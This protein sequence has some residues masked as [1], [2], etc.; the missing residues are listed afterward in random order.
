MKA[1]YVP[2]VL[3]EEGP[4]EMR[5]KSNRRVPSSGG[6]ML[7]FILT[8]VLFAPLFTFI[9]GGAS[10]EF[11]Y[12]GPDSTYGTL[13]DALDNASA[14]DIVILSEGTFNGSFRSG[15]S[16][17]VIRGNSTEGTIL[18]LDGD[19][20][21]ILE[22]S[23]IVL[24]SLTIRNGTLD[25]T[26][27]NL[28]GSDIIL[29][30]EGVSIN[31]I[32][33]TGCTLNNLSMEDT[34]GTA[35]SMTNCSSMKLAA[36]ISSNT[37]GDLIVI[38]SCLNVLIEDPALHLNKSS[39]GIVVSRSSIIS[40]TNPML[41]S[42][43]AGCT[44]M[45]L[46]NST[47]VTISSGMLSVK[48]SG[49]HLSHSSMVLVNG[50]M[51][52]VPQG[53]Y[54]GM[55]GELSDN[56]TV[57]SVSFL[58]QGS[59]KGMEL[60]QT[61]DLEVKNS[62]MTAGENATGADILNCIRASFR[63][64][65]VEGGGNR[66][67]GILIRSSRDVIIGFTD[68]STTSSD[69]VFV[70]A[71]NSTSV[72]LK[73]GD[74]NIGGDLSTGY[75]ETDICWNG[76]IHDN[77]FHITGGGAFGIRTV[78]SVDHLFDSNIYDIK[79]DGSV[80]GEVAGRRTVIDGEY[81]SAA[82]S[83]S[84]GMILEG[85]SISFASTRTYAIGEEST[86]VKVWDLSYL[87]MTGCLVDARGKSSSGMDVV[88]LSG[89]YD[90]TGCSFR[91]DDDSGILIHFDD[92][93]SIIHFSNS[94]LSSD[95][96]APA[97]WIRTLSSELDGID[98]A[99]NDIGLLVED[100]PS[101]RLRGV[102]INA[103][104]P[105]RTRDSALTVRDSEMGNA[106]MTL[107]AFGS[108]NVHF[109]DT[110]TGGISADGPSTVIISFS[111]YIL[112]TDR[113]LE[114]LPGTD[115]LFLSD[116]RKVYAS[117]YFNG[118]DPGTRL[119][120]KVGPI[121]A[122]HMIYERGLGGR[123]FNNTVH[124]FRKGTSPV[125]WDME[126]TV[127]TSA[128]GTLTF[129]SP[130][131]DYPA[132]PAGVKVTPLDTR[133]DL[134]ISWNANE[135]DTVE[136]RIYE[137]DMDDL[138]TWNRVGA[139][140]HPMA[141]W[142]TTGLGPSVRRIYRVTAWDGTWESAPS[143]IATAETR[144]LTPPG[145]P[146][147]LTV[148]SVGLHSLEIG[149]SQ[150][151]SGDLAGF[152][153]YMNGSIADDFE[154]AGF[155]GPSERSFVLSGLAWGTTY[156]FRIRSVDTSGNPSNLSG[157]LE[158]R[159]ASVQISLGVKAVYTDEGPLAGLP[160]F[161]GTASLISFNG[162]V[163]ATARLNSEGWTYFQGLEADE[164]YTVH[165]TPPP[166]VMGEENVTDGYLPVLGPVMQA[167][168]DDPEME[169]S[170]VVPYYFLPRVGT[171]E[172]EVVFGN[173]PR[174]GGVF[175]AIVILLDESDVP[176]EQKTTDADGKVS[177]TISDLP[178]RGRFDVIPPEELKGDPE[179]NTSGYLPI[180]TNFFE[181]DSS[182]TDLGVFTVE[183]NYFSYTPPPPDLYI[184]SCTPKGND[185]PLD[186]DIIIR[187][188]QPVNTDSVESHFRIY[189]ALPGMSF[190]WDE[191]GTNLTISHDGF[192][193]DMNY[194]VVIEE[195]AYSMIGTG[196][197]PGYASNTWSFHTAREETGKDNGKGLSREVIWALIIGS[198]V[199]LIIVALFIWNSSRRE[200]EELDEEDMYALSDTEFDGDMDYFD[201]EELEGEFDTD[202]YPDDLVEDLVEEMPLE[203]E[204]IEEEEEIEE[205]MEEELIE[206]EEEF[207]E[208][209]EP[210]AEE[211][212]REEEK[213]E[214]AEGE[215]GSEDV[216]E[217]LPEEEEEEA[218]K[219]PVKRHAKRNKGKKRN[220]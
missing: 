60:R 13:Q 179:Q 118:S 213:E 98:I 64:S 66:S 170:I 62:T 140:S 100:T 138:S 165:I 155:A 59:G 52:D 65:T 133:E 171:I 72:E 154:F 157:T 78:N 97:I 129:S 26:G 46:G 89:D 175:E 50:T 75:E 153:I 201:E 184:V 185:V 134:L 176:V 194:T 137:L 7:A 202:E 95:S 181:M 167:S 166:H 11:R 143:S 112:T 83:S 12:V 209:E 90:M 174:Q 23:G 198:L 43:G 145:I 69:S 67:K 92:A 70:R 164:Y 17:L 193:P 5:M 15:L 178:F 105:I 41:S 172:V 6:L 136:Y 21:S 20:H 189:P 84:T 80:G 108:S 111:I 120:G 160:V 214:M 85:S 187:F 186:A 8:A 1:R 94:S 183:L 82:G 33:T 149:W 29:E 195:G 87:N 192:L 191:Y 104:L 177:F 79:G 81:I 212:P 128:P 122:D 45:S 68:Y 102:T 142:T 144:D 27:Q 119:D 93:A 19:E 215:G 86:G 39:R 103:P 63:N 147:D 132:V 180:R 53:A 22:G 110:F 55:D 16:S 109:I 114:P 48:G 34:G 115:I 196:F 35:L 10:G 152:E 203:E 25:I 116:E 73:E 125:D 49:I 220:P 173:G 9:P 216:D 217:E 161:N 211:E 14:G 113:F 121:I 31:F 127:E 24:S 4:G 130:D 88:G 101:L 199:L 61:T 197:P 28:T 148:L 32:N 3:H 51:I 188:D 99:G 158:A 190:S 47:S 206:E 2:P 159:T 54:N 131:V 200:E 40:I 37:T 106:S 141:S 117:G 124:I 139:V 126:Y 123:L 91:G 146:F 163:I 44:G 135:D 71:A 38:E 218:Q 150:M 169:L 30:G 58:V 76:R 77:L 207:E 204:L 162:T 205:D 208:E 182:R 57:S 36:P 210:E 74:I 56:L 107:E 96:N 219:K 168:V 156:L 42:S 18:V 151:D